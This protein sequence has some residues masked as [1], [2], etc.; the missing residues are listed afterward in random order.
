MGVTVVVVRTNRDERGV[1]ADRVEEAVRVGVAAVVGDGHDVGAEPLRMAQEGALGELLGVTGEQQATGGGGDAQHD[2]VVVVAGAGQAAGRWAQHLDAGL[3]EG[4]APAGVQGGGRHAAGLG[5][6]GGGQGRWGQGLCG[7]PGGGRPDE[8]RPDVHRGEDGG[9]AADVVVVGVACD[10]DVQV[11][12]AAPAQGRPDGLGFGAAVVEHARRRVAWDLDEQRLALPDVERGDGQR[13]DPGRGPHRGPGCGCQRE[14]HGTGEQRGPAASPDERRHEQ[15]AGGGRCEMCRA[16]HRPHREGLGHP[17]HRR[18]GR[19]GKHGDAAPRAGRGLRGDGSDQ[20][21]HLRE[22]G[23]RDGDEVGGHRRERD[24]VEPREQRGG[25]P[26]LGAEGD[27]QGEA[28]RARAGEA[29]GQPRRG[30]EHATGRQHAEHEPELPREHRVG[31]EQEEHR[32]GEDVAGV[33]T[34]SEQ[35]GRQDQ[36]GHH[37]GTEHGRLPPHE[38]HVPACGGEP[39]LAAPACAHA[40][41]RRESDDAG[42]HEGH[43]PAGDDD[44]VGEPGRGE[45]LGPLPGA[46]A[47]V[48]DREARQ[49]T[50][51]LGVEVAREGGARAIADAVGGG[52]QPPRRPGGLPVR[53]VDADR[54]VQAAHVRAEPLVRQGPGRRGEGELLPHGGRVR[55]VTDAQERSLPDPYVV[56][57]GDPQEQ[58]G[59][60]S[61]WS[62]FGDDGGTHLRG[63]AGRSQRR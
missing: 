1:R 57:A 61:G 60:G 55:H 8:E 53:G 59:A 3:P 45:L 11:T 17:Q 47:G 36:S 21:D 15:E 28:Q 42:E 38:H 62:G 9:Q 56:E 14:R 24:P 37:A 49:E 50:R 19:G 46:V 33:A 31:E 5:S 44:E 7:V 41:R 23:R 43:V 13:V 26:R 20:A 25:G 30:H 16:E 35:A 54:G 32:H 10:H 27:G 39:E 29:L 63:A 58:P 48:A 52:Q 2:G 34:P 6:R 22:P 40:E 12:D 51:A 18:Q 4:E